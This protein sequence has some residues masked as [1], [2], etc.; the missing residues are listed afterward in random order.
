[1]DTFGLDEVI[2][3]NTNSNKI[4]AS[5]FD[6]NP[7]THVITVKEEFGV[8]KVSFKLE[9]IEKSGVFKKFITE[10]LHRASVMIKI[11]RNKSITVYGDHINVISESYQGD[12]NIY[13]EK[14]LVKLN[15]VKENVI[16]KLFQGN[17]FANVMDANID[18]L[19]NNGKIKVNEVIYSK[20][21][22][23]ELKNRSQK[24]KINSINANIT[25]ETKLKLKFN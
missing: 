1:M 17:I 25:L 2:I 5:L 11:P 14:G 22:K 12:L 24:I 19:S 6:E 13:I 20:K 4:E 10:R 16:I 9:F 15:E 21:Y 18:I 7:N 23:K 3:L 8:L